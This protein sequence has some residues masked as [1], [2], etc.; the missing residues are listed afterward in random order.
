M[1]FLILF[2]IPYGLTFGPSCMYIYRVAQNYATTESPINRFKYLMR[3][4]MCDV[5]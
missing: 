1:A 2:I 3:G 4:I 5:Y